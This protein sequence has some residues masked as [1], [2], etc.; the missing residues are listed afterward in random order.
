M[1]RLDDLEAQSIFIFR[2]AYARLKLAA[3]RRF[4]GRLIADVRGVQEDSPFA[5]AIGE[6]IDAWAIEAGVM[7][8]PAATRTLPV[9]GA[10]K[11]AAL[12]KWITFLLSFDIDYR[13]RRLQFLIEGQ[14]RL[15]QRLGSDRFVDLT[16]AAVDRLKR[17]LYDCVEVLERRRAAAS[18]NAASRNLIDNIFRVAPSS[19][20]IREL[21]AFA[22]SFAARHMDRLTRLVDN[23][24]ADIDLKATTRHLD[25]LL[26]DA[27]D[28]AHPAHRDEV[29]VNYL[30]FPFWDVLTFPV[31]SWREAGEFNEIRVDRISPQDATGIERLGDFRLKGTAINQFAA[32]FSRAFR[33][34]DYLLGRLHAFDRLID[35]VCDAAGAEQQAAAIKAKGFRR[36]LDVEEPHLPTCKDM[37][38][39]MR[40]A[41]AG[42]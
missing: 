15:Y 36:I 13:K 3:A 8:E 16:P 12:P 11:L 23:I 31:M 38:A 34:N 21:S 37:I 4:L 7:Y 41:L 26:T 42:T 24:G 19:A 27:E 40:A 20:E 39:K 22:T 17:K 1:D 14:N 28:L 6:I 9:E 30:G 5:R 25:V 10:T 29:L 35:I 18:L 2:E 32:F 33:E